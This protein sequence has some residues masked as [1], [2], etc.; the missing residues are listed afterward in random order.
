MLGETFFNC[1]CMVGSCLEVLYAKVQS[2]RSV[3]AE[4]HKH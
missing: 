4:F 1:I 2:S 3:M